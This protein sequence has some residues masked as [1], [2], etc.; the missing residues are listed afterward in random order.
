MLAT[1]Q[2]LP[3]ERCGGLPE[4]FIDR[5]GDNL[6]HVCGDR[7]LVAFNFPSREAAVREWNRGVERR[8]F[9]GRHSPGAGVD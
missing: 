8:S 6:C 2:P 4:H 3:C 7:C 9:S 5:G 1:P